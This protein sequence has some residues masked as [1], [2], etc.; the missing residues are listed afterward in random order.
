MGTII[1]IEL[2]GTSPE[3]TAEFYARAFGWVASASPFLPDYLMADTGE[4]AGI[5]AAIMSDTYQ[6][7]KTIIWIEVPEITAAVAAVEAA[8]GA[9]A[10]DFHDLPGQG[11][12]G[13]VTDPQGTLIGLKQIA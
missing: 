2:T 5:D 7:Q 12:V 3:A 11:R 4:G 8:G 9:A 6:R 1:H 13:Y 10:G